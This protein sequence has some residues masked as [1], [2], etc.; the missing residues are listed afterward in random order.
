MTRKLFH[1][2]FVPEHAATVHGAAGVHRQ[3]GNLVATCTQHGTKGFDERAFAR[4]GHAGNAD[5]NRFPGMGKAGPENGA[6]G[7]LMGRGAAFDEGDGAGEKGAIAREHAR[8]GFGGLGDRLSPHAF[9]FSEGHSGESACHAGFD[10]AGIGAT[11]RVFRD[12][13]RF[14]RARCDHRSKP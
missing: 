1:A 12:P 2:G 6:G 14:A 10:L 8:H 11:L 5:A 9:A 13:F 7:F 4:S 3:H